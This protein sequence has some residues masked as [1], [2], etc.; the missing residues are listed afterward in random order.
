MLKTEPAAFVTELIRREPKVQQNG[1]DLTGRSPRLTGKDI[2]ELRV[3]GMVKA[4]PRMVE[5]RRSH[6]EHRWITVQAQQSAIP[7][8]LVEDS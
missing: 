6:L 1:I 4:T 3:T 2:R 8:Q 7:P 5:H